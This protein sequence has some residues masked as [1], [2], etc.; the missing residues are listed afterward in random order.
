LSFS[1]DFFGDEQQ[2]GSVSQI[3]PFLPNL[4]LGRDVCAGIENLTKT[5][6]VSGE[7]QLWLVMPMKSLLV[8]DTNEEP[9]ICGQ[10][11]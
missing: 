8:G 4:L 11:T 5:V 2:H 9:Q 6:T 7:M 3:N 10:V 1:P